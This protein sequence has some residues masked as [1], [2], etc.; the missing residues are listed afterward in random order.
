MA[1]KFSYRAMIRAMGGPTKVAKMCNDYA[2]KTK[3]IPPSKFTIDAI[4]SKQKTKSDT[5]N[6]LLSVAAYNEISLDLNMFIEV[7]LD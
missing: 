4:S 3:K 7:D 2:R 5:F 1:L 6:M